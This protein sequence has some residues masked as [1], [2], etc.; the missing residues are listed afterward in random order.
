[1]WHSVIWRRLQA[2][3]AQQAGTVAVQD[4][5]MSIDGVTLLSMASVPQ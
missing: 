2:Q 4:G 5:D 1:M 3:L